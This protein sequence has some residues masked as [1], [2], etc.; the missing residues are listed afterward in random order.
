MGKSELIENRKNEGIG[1]SGSDGD[2]GPF[3]F[4]FEGVLKDAVDGE[5]ERKGLS[6]VSLFSLDEILW[7]VCDFIFF[8]E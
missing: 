2:F 7:I 4:F 3:F 6:E 1:A 5:N 8:E